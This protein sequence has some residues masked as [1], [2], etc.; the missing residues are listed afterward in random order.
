MT[1]LLPIDGVVTCGYGRVL[2]LT[3]FTIACIYVCPTVP[4]IPS[5]AT[6]VLDTYLDP[7]RLNMH[8]RLTSFGSPCSSNPGVHTCVYPLGTTSHNYHMETEVQQMEALLFSANVYCV[9]TLRGVSLCVALH[10]TCQLLPPDC[11]RV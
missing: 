5:E 4:T 2:F 3:S 7:F 9:S 6:W 10:S 8:P 1:Q 11:F